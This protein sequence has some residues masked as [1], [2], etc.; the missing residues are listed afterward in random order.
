[1]P[2]NFTVRIE[3]SSESVTVFASGSGL[4]KS[5]LVFHN[6]LPLPDNDTAIIDFAASSMLVRS[7]K[8]QAADYSSCEANTL[9][10]L[11]PGNSI[12]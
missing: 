8:D 2:V 1:V 5:D 7:A 9:R 3:L 6:R 12:G 11:S 4:L 10:D